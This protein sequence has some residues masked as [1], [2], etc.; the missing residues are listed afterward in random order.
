[1][2]QMPAGPVKRFES[3]AASVP[4][5]PVSEMRGK[6]FAA[7]HAD[8]GVGGDQPLLGLDQVGAPQQQ[9]GGQPRGRHGAGW[10][11]SSGARATVVSWMIARG[12]RPSSTAS[13]ASSASRCRCERRQL[14]PRAL[15]LGLELAQVELGD[16][17]RVGAFALQ[18]E[19]VRARRSS[20]RSVAVT[21]S[22]S[23]R[24]AK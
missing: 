14:R 24:S 23:E 13:A 8:A 16:Q 19:R 9:L 5:S 18:L 17:A 22:S 15:D 21:C 20:D 12:L 11:R 1:M 4:T 2:V 6:K 7:R 3:D 10:R